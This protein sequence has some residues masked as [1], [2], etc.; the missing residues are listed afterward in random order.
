MR[1]I[2]K[3]IND[4]IKVIKETNIAKSHLKRINKIENNISK[5]ETKL[6]IEKKFL[7]KEKKEASEYL[8]NKKYNHIYLSFLNENMILNT[9]TLGEVTYYY[10]R[11]DIDYD[12]INIIYLPK[13]TKD[14]SIS[15]V[16]GFIKNIKVEPNKF[17]T[18]FEIKCD[19]EKVVDKFYKSIQY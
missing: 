7:L 18:C 1:K 14:V 11:D 19:N 8:N 2:H 15:F 17:N 10:I 6:N 5:L 13:G 9:G 12:K 3:T 4:L 16:Q